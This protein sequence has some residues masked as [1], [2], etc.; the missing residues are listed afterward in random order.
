MSWPLEC[1]GHWAQDPR[2]GTATTWARR[3]HPGVH[4]TVAARKVRSPVQPW[5]EA[6]QR[7]RPRRRCRPLA[8][9]LCG[10]PAPLQ[11]MRETVIPPLRTVGAARSAPTRSAV[12]V[13]GEGSPASGAGRPFIG[14]MQSSR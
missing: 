2:L 11:V 12:G 7:G 10:R 14:H 4:S 6:G 5:A 3:V 1:L 9:G 8:D 13:S